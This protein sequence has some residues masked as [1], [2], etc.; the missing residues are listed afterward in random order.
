MKYTKTMAKMTGKG[1]PFKTD[2]E[3]KKSE[4][5]FVTSTNDK[6]GNFAQDTSFLPVGSKYKADESYDEDDYEKEH[7]EHS[8][9][10]IIQD[11]SNVQSKSKKNK[12]NLGGF[13]QDD[14]MK[15]KD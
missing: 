15:A 12:P 13:T 14:F 1:F 8:K 6:E 3:S 4:D 11:V 5:L 9:K 10:Y 7:P 2:D